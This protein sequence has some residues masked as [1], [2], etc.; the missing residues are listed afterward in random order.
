MKI[1]KNIYLAGFVCV[2]LLLYAGK[3][4]FAPSVQQAEHK[5]VAQVNKASL[6]AMS[7]LP[8]KERTAMG[9]GAVHAVTGVSS[10]SEAFPDSQDVQLESALKYG[11]PGVRNR[12][13]AAGE[14]D[15]LVYIGNSPYYHLDR[16]TQSVP[17]LVPRAAVL[18][19]DIGRSY[20]DSLAVKGIPLHQFVLSSVLRTETDVENLRKKNGNATERSC[21]LF[22][23]TFDIAYNRYY[24]VASPAPDTL[25]TSDA[26]LKF[27]LS[28]V[29]RDMRRAGRCYVKYEVKQGCFHITV[30]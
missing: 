29:L 16:L 13:E 12:R 4:L 30:R 9:G 19:S 2:V 14:K 10:Y 11:V 3:L 7:V 1:T 25:T 23:T 21:H 5:A 17:Y 22:G 28:E 18:L 8:A 26:R 24:K 27:V 20:Y 15:R 6:R